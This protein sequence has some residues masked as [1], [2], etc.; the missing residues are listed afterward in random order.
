MSLVDCH[1]LSGHLNMQTVLI[2]AE[3]PFSSG[4]DRLSISYHNTTN[5]TQP[6]ANSD[7][8]ITK[9]Y[10]F[11]KNMLHRD[12]DFFNTDITES[13]MPQFQHIAFAYG[14]NADFDNLPE[15]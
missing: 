15:C 4:I 8:I 2:I 9:I 5:K 7:I 13:R 1:H 3:C 10:G 12:F 6:I 11:T 14:D